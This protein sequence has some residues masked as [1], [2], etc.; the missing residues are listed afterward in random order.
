MLP[1][2]ELAIE[3]GTAL[4]VV[5]QSRQVGIDAGNEAGCTIRWMA[6]SPRPGLALL[7]RCHSVSRQPS[8]GCGNVATLCS[9]TCQLHFVVMLDQIQ[10][11]REMLFTRAAHSIATSVIGFSV[12][13]CSV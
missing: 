6:D 9:E 13:D 8:S 2:V 12:A 7:F 4:P 1:S 10:L 5:R 11:P 3:E